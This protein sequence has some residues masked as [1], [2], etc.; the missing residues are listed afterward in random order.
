MMH[1]AKIMV[2]PPESPVERSPPHL[3]LTAANLRRSLAESECEHHHENTLFIA[4]V[5]IGVVYIERVQALVIVCHVV[6]QIE[7]VLETTRKILLH[8]SG[9]A[10]D[11][12]AEDVPQALLGLAEHRSLDALA[13]HVVPQRLGGHLRLVD[14]RPREAL[15]QEDAGEVRHDLVP[16]HGADAV[17][18]PLLGV[19]RGVEELRRVRVDLGERELGLGQRLREVGVVLPVRGLRHLEGDLLG[20]G[21]P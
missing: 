5:F 11:A 20:I 16:R 10:T 15:E 13:L 17:E 6:D 12:E 3:H 7:P 14:A 18:L 2:H 9:N 21:V 19:P 1:C 4:A 8:L